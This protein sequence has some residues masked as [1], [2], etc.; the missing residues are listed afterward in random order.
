MNVQW[1]Y[2]RKSLLVANR[3]LYVAKASHEISHQ[4]PRY[5]PVLVYT[6]A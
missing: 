1:M 5:D 6:K 3:I 4:T 2:R